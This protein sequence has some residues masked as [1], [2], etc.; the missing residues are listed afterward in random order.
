MKD[1]LLY[2]EY[3]G[4]VHFNADDEI[5]YGKIEGIDDLISF[6]GSSV[7][8]LKKA[9]EDSVN[10]YLEL[11]SKAGKKL[12]KSYKGSFNVRISPEIHKR[13]KQIAVRKGISLNQFVQKA[14]EDEVI[15]ESENV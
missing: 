3:L 13:A 2:K 15:K 12:E 14:V 4:S 1:I 6:E 7:K 5:F 8:E 10:D 9:F 11:C